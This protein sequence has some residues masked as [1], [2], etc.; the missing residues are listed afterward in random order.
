MTFIKKIITISIFSATANAGQPPCDVVKTIA[1]K[2]DSDTKI[3]GN[4]IAI[5]EKHVIANDHSFF[6]EGA[7]TVI[8][9]MPN[10]KMYPSRIVVRDFHYNTALL[11]INGDIKLKACEFHNGSVDTK[12][13]DVYGFQAHLSQPEHHQVDV[14]STS[15]GALLVPGVGTSIELD[16]TFH[17]SMSGSPAFFNGRVIGVLSQGSASETSLLIPSAVIDQQVKNSLALSQSRK[18]SFRPSDQKFSFKGF[19]LPYGKSNPPVQLPKITPPH[20]GKMGGGGVHEGMTTNPSAADLF[21]INFNKDVRALRMARESVIINITDARALYLS[22]PKMSELIVASGGKRVAVY[23][24][25]GIAIENNLDF[26]RVMESCTQ[27]KMDR[28]LIVDAEEKHITDDFLDLALMINNLALKMRPMIRPA[29]AEIAKTVFSTLVGS[30]TFLAEMPI[31]GNNPAATQLAHKF[32]QS[33]SR[34]GDLVTEGA[35]TEEISERITEID[36]TIAKLRLKAQSIKSR[37]IL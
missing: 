32:I 33:W 37:G 21:K 16:L 28:F 12:S 11:V 20:E 31:H 24:I 1:T 13:V 6:R 7:Q 30:L 27:C 17:E 14:L 10:G 26:I 9:G 2:A 25:D 4:A 36:L 22:Q 19:D 5:D 35:I 23:S 15:S 8:L 3:Y 34:F 18:Y 29:N